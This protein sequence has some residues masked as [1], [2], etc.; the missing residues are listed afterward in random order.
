LLP[1]FSGEAVRDA[2][3]HVSGKATYAVTTNNKVDGY[4]TWGKKQQPNRLDTF[5]SR[6]RRRYIQ[7]GLDVEP[8]VRAHTYKGEWDSVVSDRAFF[9]NPWRPVPL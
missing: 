4:A 5:S 8:V 7:R 2:L 1:N 9:R 6:R 3:A